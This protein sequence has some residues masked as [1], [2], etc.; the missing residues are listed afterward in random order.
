MS[1]KFYLPIFI[2][3]GAQLNLSHLTEPSLN[4]SRLFCTS[5]TLRHRCIY[6]EKSL[7]ETLV[8]QSLA[9]STSQYYF[10]L[11]SCTEHVP[12]RLCTTKLAQSTS[13]YH[14]VLQSLHKELS[15]MTLYYKACTEH[16][17]YYFVLQSLPEHVTVLLCTTKL[18]QS[19]S[20]YYFV[21]QSTSS[22][23]LS[24][25]S[26]DT[27]SKLLHREAFT[28]RIVYTEKLSYCLIHNDSRNCSSKAGSRRQIKKNTMLNHF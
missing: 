24:H 8:A 15:S 3:S 22:V 21:L 27:H 10:V 4:S 26:F 13:L 2:S 7:Q 25:R 1:A 19:T 20:Q 5:E 9:Q 11:Q 18:E 16:V 12:V 23:A 17:Q 14:K 28:Q 6:T